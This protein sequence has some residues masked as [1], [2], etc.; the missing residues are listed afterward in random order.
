M[1]QSTSPAPLINEHEVARL[2]ALSVK[3]IRRWRWSGRGPRFLKIG[4]AVRYDP[5]DISALKQA[6]RRTSTTDTGAREKEP[7]P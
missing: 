5:A 4:A 2:L 3:T 1:S 7:A 6:A